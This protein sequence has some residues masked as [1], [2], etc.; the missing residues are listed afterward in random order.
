MNSAIFEQT[1]TILYD[2]AM[3]EKRRPV[4]NMPE[5][6]GIYRLFHYLCNDNNNPYAW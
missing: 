6:F 2:L 5:K 4:K 1:F 3:S